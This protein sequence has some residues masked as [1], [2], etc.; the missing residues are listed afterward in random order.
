MKIFFFASDNN[1]TSGAFL[2]MVKLCT[3]LKEVYKHKIIVVLPCIGEGTKLLQEAGIEFRVI[4]SYHW[5]VTNKKNK[6]STNVHMILKMLLNIKAQNN[7]KR[8]LEKERPD[9]VHLNTT[10]T[11]IGAKVAK[12]CHIP[13][14][15]HLR[16]FLEEDQNVKIWNRRYGYRLI[17]QADKIIAISRSIYNK[18][19]PFFSKEKLAIVYNGLD[20]IKFHKA[21]HQ[22]F[23]KDTLE[24]AIVGTVHENKGQAQAIEACRLLKD[25]ED[26]NFRLRIIGK[27]D[28]TYVDKLKSYVI[29]NNL[30]RYVVFCGMQSKIEEIYRETD[31]TLVC[32]RAEAFGRTTVEAMMAGTLVIG[33]NNAGTSELIK[34]QETGV[35]YESGNCVD[36]K[37]KIKMVLE[38]REEMIEV[39]KNGQKFMLQNM[40]ANINAQNINTIYDEILKK[41]K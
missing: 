37:N 6:L 33:A 25:E 35:L 10:Y 18:Y 7:I 11:Y 5:C 17:G 9:L 20:E 14:V 32:S 27:G 22:I 21:S 13:Y 16:E 30:E 2:S 4:K 23:Q 41:K 36:L 26:A 1:E 40:T 19:I 8:M 12:Q 24:L 39:A 31:I 29:D 28:K 15:W 38:N 3:V 34:N